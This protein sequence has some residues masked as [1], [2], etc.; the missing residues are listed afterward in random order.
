MPFKRP[1][2]NEHTGEEYPDAFWYPSGFG[3]EY[4]N[5]LITATYVGHLSQNHLN[6]EPIP[7]MLRVF[8]VK[9]AAFV[10]L[11]KQI[12]ASPVAAD[13]PLPI[14]IAAML[15]QIVLQITHPDQGGLKVGDDE[16]GNP[17]YQSFFHGCTPLPPDLS[18]LQ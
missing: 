5:Q 8:N 14:A 9:G 18:V 16:D 7:A 12:A 13:T 2:I 15:D 10:A 6:K 3:V 1:F 17:I 4:N 11:L